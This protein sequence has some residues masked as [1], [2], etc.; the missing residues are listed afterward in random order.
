MKNLI[1]ALPMNQKVRLTMY[2]G[3]HAETFNLYGWC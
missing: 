1:D 3:S 2:Y